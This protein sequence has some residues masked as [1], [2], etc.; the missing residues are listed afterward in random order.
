[1]VPLLNTKHLCSFV[2]TVNM[3]AVKQHNKEEKKKELQE[4]S[5][6]IFLPSSTQIS[7]HMNSKI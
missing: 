1:M 6:I 3:L 5:L 4:F 7:S 2:N